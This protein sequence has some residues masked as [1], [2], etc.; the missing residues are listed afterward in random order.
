MDVAGDQGRDTAD[1]GRILGRS[2]EKSW[3][4]PTGFD[5]LDDGR[6]LS[7]WRRALRAGRGVGLWRLRPVDAPRRMVRAR[8]GRGMSKPS[9]LAT[10]AARQGAAAD[11]AN[12]VRLGASA[13]TGKTQVLSA[14]VLRLMLDGVSPHAILCITFTKAGAA[15][16]AHRIRDRLAA[17]VRMA[18]G[19]L[20]L[21]LQALGFD[22]DL[23]G[24][25]SGVPALMRRARAP[26]ATVRARPGHRTRV[27]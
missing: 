20:R 18:D 8:G 13:G 5:P 19:D 9:G 22:L 17:W 1:L 7:V 4:R 21:D 24:Y 3:F 11:P 15:E 12:H 10:L 2:R 27:V 25:D 26:F 14:R 16:M 6:A 23:L